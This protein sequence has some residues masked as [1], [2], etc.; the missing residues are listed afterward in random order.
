MWVLTLKNDAP[1]WGA[2]VSL[3]LNSLK[4]FWIRS[5]RCAIWFK[6]RACNG[7]TSMKENGRC[8]ATKCSADMCK[9]GTVLGL[10]SWS[11]W[12]ETA[13]L[14]CAWADVL[15]DDRS[16]WYRFH[17]TSWLFVHIMRA[18]SLRSRRH[19]RLTLVLS[20]ALEM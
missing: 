3:G 4:C 2:V 18:P 20:S 12:Q 8:L 14:T 15:K 10:G 17:F 11:T 5:H 16:N 9:N 7:L 1:S 19:I 6:L 13:P